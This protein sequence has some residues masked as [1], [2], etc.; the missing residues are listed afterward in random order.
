MCEGDH[1]G[2]PILQRKIYTYMFLVALLRFL[3]YTVENNHDCSKKSV[4]SLIQTVGSGTRTRT[5]CRK[6]GGAAI[7]IHALCERAHSTLQKS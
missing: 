4:N 1:L 6:G 5:I 3:T 7:F 2:R